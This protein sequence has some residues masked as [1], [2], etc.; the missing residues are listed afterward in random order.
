MVLDHFKREK[1]LVTVIWVLFIWV[2][3][4]GK[5]KIDVPAARSPRS[6]LTSKSQIVSLEYSGK[7]M[8]GFVEE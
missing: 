6:G 1:K 5:I 7:V 3:R 2:W 8:Y 4:V